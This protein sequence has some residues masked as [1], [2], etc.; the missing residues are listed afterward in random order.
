MP[1]GER[2]PCSSRRGKDEGSDDHRGEWG[3]RRMFSTSRSG[4][5]QAL[6]S[7]PTDGA[8]QTLLLE[9]PGEIGAKAA[10]H[11]SAT[12]FLTSIAVLQTLTTH[13]TL[14]VMYF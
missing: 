13:G 6:L 3:G 9:S 12:A 8:L 11:L 5:R 7:W 1:Q 2:G 4:H 10:L 14:G